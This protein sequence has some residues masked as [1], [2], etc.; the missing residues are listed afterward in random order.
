MVRDG[1]T[2]PGEERTKYLNFYNFK[3]GELDTV[4]ENLPNV[5]YKW[6]NYDFLYYFQSQNNPTLINI[7]DM[8]TRN[9]HE[10]RIKTL[11]EKDTML[12]RVDRSKD[13]QEIKDEYLISVYLKR[14]KN[15]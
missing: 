4:F 13:N 7:Y 12:L 14:E 1:I 5:V 6:N 10:I 11:E 15:Y 8:E 3:T 9:S 2:P